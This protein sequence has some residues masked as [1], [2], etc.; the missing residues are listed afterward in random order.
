MQIAAHQFAHVFLF[1]C[2]TCSRPLVTVC[3]SKNRNLEV[4]DSR[5]FQPLCHCGWNGTLAGVEALKHWREP[6]TNE[7]PVGAGV[8]GSCEE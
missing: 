4:G 6:W 5:Q 2:P 7:A 8:K 1:A 3:N